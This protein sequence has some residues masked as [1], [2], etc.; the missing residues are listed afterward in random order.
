MN[1]KRLL[2][3]SLL[4][5]GFLADMSAKTRKVIYVIMDGIPAD[6]IERLH[7]KTIYDIA[8]VGRY[9]RG[10]AGGEV[11]TYSQTPTVSAIG[12]SNILTGTWMNKHNVQGNSDM[13][14]NYNYWSIFRIAKAQ[15][16]DYKT[17]IFS[18][19]TDNRTILLGAGKSE[20][21]NLKVD[22]VA[23]GYDLD[24]AKFPQQKNSTEI[25]QIDSLVI[26]KAAQCVKNNAPDLSWTYLWYTD[27][28]F[29]L[30]G[31]GSYSD[32]YV[33]KTDRQLKKIWDAVK[34]REKHCNEEWMII[35]TTDHG[36]TENGHGHGG[37]SQ[38]ERCVW[39]STNIKNVNKEFS[40]SQL[41]HVD[42]LPT[43]CRFM[44]FEVPNNLLFEEDGISFIGKRDIYNLTAFPYDDTITLN[45]KSDV[46]AEKATIFMAA[47][48]KFK[49]GVSDEWIEVA[50]VPAK[51]GVYKIDLKKYTLSKFYKF[52]IVTPNN[53]LT[54]WVER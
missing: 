3:L 22:D 49:E 11:G 36:R 24:K 52:A 47:T 50:T 21:N 10:Y 15:K 27:D 33:M 2:L 18:S 45:W 28:A 38:R 23:D 39:M 6:C 51:Q 42:I 14:P 30:F 48:N 1:S 13:K 17:A 7:P 41:S 32:D 43:I 35:V 8:A 34:Y 19:W 29:H 4:L 12:Y 53:H 37:Q 44:N 16:K 54:R 26:D 5:L 31:N 25:W 9:S 40:S 20:T 46:T